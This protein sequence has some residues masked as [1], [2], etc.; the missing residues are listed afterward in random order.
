MTELRHERRPAS[1]VSLRKNPLHFWHPISA[2]FF[3]RL[4][5]SNA[6]KSGLLLPYQIYNQGA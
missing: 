4:R 3:R 5:P 1:V 2:R 6:R